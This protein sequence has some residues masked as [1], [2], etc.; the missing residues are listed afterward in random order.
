MLI[1]NHEKQEL[2]H[3]DSFTIVFHKESHNKSLPI[4]LL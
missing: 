1:R 2:I 4:I 3:R